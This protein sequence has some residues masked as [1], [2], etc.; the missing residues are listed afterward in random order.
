MKQKIKGGKGDKLN[1]KD[2]DLTQLK[3][4]IKVE[5]EHTKDTS[6]AKEIALDHLAEDP[7]Y[8]SKLK[9]AKLEEVQYKDIF[10]PQTLSTLKGKSG[11]SL[12]QLMGN[13]NLLQAAMRSRELLLQLSKIEA[14]YID[15]LENEAIDIIKK[16]YPIID[17]SDIEID[18]KIVQGSMISQSSPGEQEENNI[19]VAPEDKKRRLINAITQG[20]SVRGAFAY[21]LFREALDILDDDLV[22]KYSELLKLTFG[23]FDDENAIAMFLA[24]LAQQ[25]ATSPSGGESEFEYDEEKDKFII[26]ARALN[27]PFL[28]HE[29]VKGLYE[30]LATQGFSTDKEKNKQII[31][32][33]DKVTNEPEDMRYG[34]FIYDAINQ[35]YSESNFDDP[36]IRD[37]LYTEIYKLD[38]EEFL[39]FI[40]NIINNKLTKNQKLWALGVMKDIDKDLHKD[41][42]NLEDLD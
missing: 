17:Y 10:S 36:R 26:K 28:V 23:V 32:K 42:T 13:K 20:A 9:K 33:V 19:E 15:I 41:D 35:L 24:M 21:L 25:G 39:L 2:V 16:A 38:N 3:M 31:S 11:E 18:A 12:R 22:N 5:M 30:I 7:K 27:F 8:Y 6:L 40:D 37:F 14:P 1:P 4:G 29:I 34:K